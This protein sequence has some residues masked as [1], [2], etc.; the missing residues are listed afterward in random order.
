[1]EEVASIDVEKCYGC[2]NCV[3]ACPVQAII[4]EEARPPEFIRK[5]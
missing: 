3:L 2:G 5:T 1:V 4:L